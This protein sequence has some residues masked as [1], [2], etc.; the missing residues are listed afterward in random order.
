MRDG[1]LLFLCPYSNVL[2]ND[3]QP[4]SVPR[5]YVFLA[6]LKHL[7][8]D[9]DHE[10]LTVLALASTSPRL[11]KVIL[12]CK[13]RQCYGLLPWSKYG[14]LD[15]TQQCLEVNNPLEMVKFSVLKYHVLFFK[16]FQIKRFRTIHT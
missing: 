15:T 5:I 12:D 3:P 13:E 16:N 7:V 9:V 1:W 2:I 8:V 10:Q 14:T 6:I 11:Y 4:L